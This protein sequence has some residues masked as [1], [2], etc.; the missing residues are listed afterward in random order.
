MWTLAIK[1]KTPVGK[2]GALGANSGFI[3]T[4]LNYR[5]RYAQS[6]ADYYFTQVLG[7]FS[8]QVTSSAKRNAYQ[9]QPKAS[10]IQNRQRPYVMALSCA[11]HKNLILPNQE[12]KKALKSLHQGFALMLRLRY[13]SRN[14]ALNA[15]RQWFRLAKR[16]E[17]FKLVMVQR[18]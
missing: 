1:N 17:L 6:S 2:T 7:F 13:D 16:E 9:P 14:S 11:F 4:S 18:Y 5:S 8:Y 15:K 12:G 3:T 10:F